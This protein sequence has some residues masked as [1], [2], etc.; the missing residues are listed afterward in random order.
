MFPLPR[1]LVLESPAM[2]KA[3]VMVCWLW[4]TVG[5]TLVIWWVSLSSVPTLCCVT[6]CACSAS[7]FNIRSVKVKIRD[8]S[9]FF[10]LI[11]ERKEVQPVRSPPRRKF[12]FWLLALR[13]QS[14]GLC[15]ARTQDPV[16]RA[17]FIV[18][19][20][21]M[22]NWNCTKEVAGKA[23]R[24]QDR[25]EMRKEVFLILSFRMFESARIL[26]LEGGW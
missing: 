23:W 5:G 10:F 21:K 14:G 6:H 11:Y 19:I 1:P 26:E 12:A 22:P 2:Q 8:V 16:C 24:C 18:Q 3:L 7:H 15:T 13:G 9:F 4:N 25:A 17:V 20:R